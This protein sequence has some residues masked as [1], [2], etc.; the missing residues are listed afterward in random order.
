[1]VHHHTELEGQ[2][3]AKVD[4]KYGSKFERLSI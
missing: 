1:M 2:S 3:I 4:S